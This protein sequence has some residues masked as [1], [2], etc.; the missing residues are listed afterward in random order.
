LLD[1]S[2]YGNHG[3]LTNMDAGT[4]WVGSQ[5]GWALDF[6]GVDDYVSIA[7]GNAITSAKAPI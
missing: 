3:T 4:D 1:R 5:Y 6:D 7:T 2:G